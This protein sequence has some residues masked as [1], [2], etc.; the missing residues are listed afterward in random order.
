[1]ED[2]SMIKGPFPPEM[3]YT[4]LTSP[5]ALIMENKDNH[6]NT[7]TGKRADGSPDGKQSEPPMDTRNTRGKYTSALPAF[8]GIEFEECYG[9]GDWEDWGRG[10]E[11]NAMTS[12]ALSESRGTMIVQWDDSH[13]TGPPYPPSIRL[14]VELSVANPFYRNRVLSRTA[15]LPQTVISNPPERRRFLQT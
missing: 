4:T 5:A 2:E 11:N 1:M 3:C 6:K 14:F 8:W 9:I 15:T 7:Q 13:T 10:G 12:P